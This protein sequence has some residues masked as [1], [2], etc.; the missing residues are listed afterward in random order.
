MKTRFAAAALV[1]VLGW[2]TCVSAETIVTKGSQWRWL[3][4]T[5]GTDPAKNDEDFHSTFFRNAFDDFGWN[6]GT[7]S[8]GPHGG[9]GYGE[10][11]FQGVDIGQPQD[12]NNRKTAYFRIKF[13]TEKDYENLV[14]KCQ[15]DDGIIVYLDGAEVLRDSMGEDDDAYDL[16]AASVAFDDETKV[17]E[18]KLPGNLAAGEHALAISLHNREGGS[19]DLRIAEISLESVAP[20]EAVATEPDDVADRRVVADVA[21]DVVADQSAE[22]VSTEDPRLA[23]PR[24]LDWPCWRGPTLNGKSGVTGIKKDWS[25]GLKKLWEVDDLCQGEGNTSTWSAP[26]IVGNRLVIPGRHGDKDVIFCFNADTGALIWKREYVTTPDNRQGG[27]DRYGSGSFA[28]PN[29]DDDRVYTYGGWGDLAC[30]KLE[31]GDPIWKINVRDLGGISAN[32]GFTSSP[33]VYQDKVIVKGGGEVMVVALNKMTGEI[34]WKRSWDDGGSGRPG[35]GSP[36]LA[37]LGGRDQI[38]VSSTS[39]GQRRG[40]HY[41]GR[42]AAL[43]PEHGVVLWEVPWWCFYELFATPVVEG[44]IAVVATGMRSGSM[45]LKVDR[46]GARV[47]WE[48]WENG[49][50]ASSHSLPVILNGNIYGYSGHSSGYYEQ[51]RTGR[52]LQCVDLM[53]GQLKWK[54]DEETRWGNVIYVDGLLLCLT[55][56]GKL[57]LV[58]ASP[59]GYKK[60]TSFQTSLNIVDS[61]YPEKSQFAWTHPI[62]AHGKVYVRY[63][64]QL[65]CYD[66]MN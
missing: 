56:Q 53:T 37:H 61:G 59:D 20:G 36:V 25:G 54:G 35:Y 41:R 19:S 4:P 2:V 63:C 50:L 62:V 39:A 5:D 38:L 55:D 48:N 22:E 30:W 11:D 12:R 47:L 3:H 9:F 34:V 46:S 28:S 40:R 43:D 27:G 31:S 14:L 58:D 1:A 52:E 24:A 23:E 8:A 7:D 17:H 13:T 49:V 44:P 15:R 10:R 18:F 51:D 57:L 32:F 64:S 60:I 45:G 66:L 33:L 65:I 29:I 16:F 6:Q 42:V 21:P 26:S